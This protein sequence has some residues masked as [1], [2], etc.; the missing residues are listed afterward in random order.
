M[1]AD[2][3]TQSNGAEQGAWARPVSVRRG[4]ALMAVALLATAAFFMWQAVLLPFGK[5]GLPGPGFF[6]FAL[7]F[8]L[9]I[10][11]VAILYQVLRAP[12]ENGVVHFGHRNVLV[13][14]AALMGVAFA[15]E[16]TDTYLALGTFMAVL[17][18]FVA[19]TSLWRVV[20]GASL[21][22]VAVWIVFGQALGVRLPAGDVW[23]A[24]GSTLG[25]AFRGLL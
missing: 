17:L 1:A 23:D 12:T 2:R 25:T 19:R 16:R 14:F 6:P 3:D 8:A 22:M 9:A 5:I 10:F 11:A 21:G 13:A 4:E 15:F 24:L 18:L 20:L 7:G